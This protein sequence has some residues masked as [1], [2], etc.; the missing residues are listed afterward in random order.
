MVM[1]DYRKAR[2]ELAEKIGIDIKELT[3]ILYKEKVEDLYNRFEIP[4][5]NGGVRVI[6]APDK[7]IKKIQKNLAK[8]LYK[9]H[10]E[11]VKEKNIQKIISHGFEKHKSIITNAIPHKHKRYILNIDI[12]DFFDSFHFGRVRGYFQNSNE[13]S[14]SKEFS[15]I[16]AQL[17]CL[18]SKLPQGAPTSPL[19]A[20]LIF[21]IV[22]LR[23]LRIVKKYKLNYT[24]YADDM[25]FSTNSWEFFNNY[26]KFIGELED[27]LDRS[28]FKINHNKTRLQYAFSHQEVT[29]LT[30]NNKVNANKV[31]IKNTRAMANSLYKTGEF[32]IQEDVGTLNQLEGRFAFINQ[33]DWYNNK[34]E[35]IN[36]LS[37]KNKKI[38]KNY[39]NG[40]NSREKQYRSF[41]FYK[42]FF[43]PLKPT[44]VVEGKTDIIH[45]KSALKKYYKLYPNLITKKDG[46]FIFKVYFLNKTKRLK[47][48]FGL[49]EDGADTMKNIWNFYNG[50]DNCEN[51]YDYLKNKRKDD[52]RKFPVI[53]LFDNEQK[54]HRKPL[55][56]FMKHASIKLEKGEISKHLQD[57]LYLQTIP[58]VNDSDECEIEDLYYD[59]ILNV[60]IRGKRFN[61]DP[62]ADS[63]KFFS[64]HFFSTYIS[65]N[66]ENINFERFKE[67]L[68]SINK[69]VDV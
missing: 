62:K 7:K 68:D 66:Y 33:L 11:Y 32:K 47:Y 17:V 44:I 40:M 8:F 25:S 30:V 67:I 28:G 2:I 37:K 42:Y 12:S 43:C 31:F 56:K 48:F 10:L 53:L 54:N 21:N 65:K 14:Y 57:N 5:R 38:E 50:K 16:I 41:L 1:T 20:N 9:E 26:N 55:Y 6:Y 35:Y 45:I 46:Q 64:K 19:I 52:F 34:F 23:I 29:G 51:I 3:N 60:T 61:K 13:F 59:D 24:R 15:T 39:I 63:E 18:D 58:L 69:I 36:G 27:L 49:V 22:D 4:K